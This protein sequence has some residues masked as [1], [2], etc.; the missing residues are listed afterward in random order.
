MGGR[1]GWREG[2]SGGKWVAAG[3]W[4]GQWLGADCRRGP[5]VCRVSRNP[6]SDG[7]VSSGGHGQPYGLAWTG[8]PWRRPGGTAGACWGGLLPNTG[9]AGWRAGQN[10]RS[11]AGEAPRSA[12]WVRTWNRGCAAQPQ[13]LETGPAPSGVAGIGLDA[14]ELLW[15]AIVSGS[16][17]RRLGW[18]AAGGGG[19]WCDAADE[20]PCEEEEVS[21]GGGRED[22]PRSCWGI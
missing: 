7:L 22:R 1:P 9:P 16:G 4:V 2:M 6:L 21:L 8:S 17:I 19:N 13:R 3:G 20:E 18:E 11:A 12:G 15:Q 10:A 5:E 14:G